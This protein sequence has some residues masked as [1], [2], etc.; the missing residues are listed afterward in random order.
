MTDRFTSWLERPWTV[1]QAIVYGTLAVGVLDGLAA[2]ITFGL[3]GTTPDRVFQGIAFGLIGRATYTGGWPTVLLGILLHF[4]VAL[5]VVAVYVAASRAAP[6]LARRPLVFGP[7][8]G[9]VAFFVMNL[10]VI[11][12]SVIGTVT[13]RWP[14]AINGLLIHALLVG[15]PAAVAAAKIHAR[16]RTAVL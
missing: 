5:G 14:G 10:V 7:I 9:M 11:P 16:A 3:R 8:Y 6:A 2:I 12:L 13:L 1:G 4:I 15:P